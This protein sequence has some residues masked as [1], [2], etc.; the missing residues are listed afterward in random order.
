MARLN[1]T[2]LPLHRRQVNPDWAF[3]E[4][5]FIK[6]ITNCKKYFINKLKLAGAVDKLNKI[7][8]A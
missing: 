3:H 2:N 6:R 7:L 4:I 1:D 5:N 8:L